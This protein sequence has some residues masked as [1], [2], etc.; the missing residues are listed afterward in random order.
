MIGAAFAAQPGINAAAGKVLGSP[1]PAAVLSIAITLISSAGLMFIT[2]T[3]PSWD[4]FSQLPWWV[5]L[6]GLIGVLVVAGGAA[7]VPITGVAVFFVCMIFGQLV[8]S[9]FLDHVGAFGL[10][11]QEIS[12]LRV[13]G[14]ILT[15][16]GV[17][18]VRY[19]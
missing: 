9:V 6:G 7:I 13:C 8:G 16:A 2:R 14:L 11:V 5:V 1:I 12:L 10:P 15:L 17:I 4:M 18:C 19:G 3:T